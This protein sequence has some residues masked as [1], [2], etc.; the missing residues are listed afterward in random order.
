MSLT[1]ILALLMYPLLSAL[2]MRLTEACKKMRSRLA[3]REQKN[4]KNLKRS[5]SLRV[6][7]DGACYTALVNAKIE[8]CKKLSHIFTNLN[9]NT[10]IIWSIEQQTY[11]HTVIFSASMAADPATAS[12]NSSACLLA[13][14]LG[15]TTSTWP[16]AEVTYAEC[17]AMPDGVAEYARAEEFFLARFS[18]L[19]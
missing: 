4:I 8:G 10:R 18:G 5:T 2:M 1:S 7:E 6:D 16:C 12:E 14:R 15:R 19:L 3:Q 11:A 13:M 9:G 17:T